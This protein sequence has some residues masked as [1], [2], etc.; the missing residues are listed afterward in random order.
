MSFASSSNPVDVQLHA[1]HA[2]S[3]STH[4]RHSADSP[5]IQPWYSVSGTEL[6][7]R[8][9]DSPIVRECQDKLDTIF[10]SGFNNMIQALKPLGTVIQNPL[11]GIP[12][13]LCAMSTFN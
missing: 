9:Q 10:S 8:E 2:R 3:Q 6:R 12:N 11:A 7:F 1:L 5:R 13:L 4:Y